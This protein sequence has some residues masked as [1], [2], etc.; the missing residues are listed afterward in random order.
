MAQA[1][2]SDVHSKPLERDDEKLRLF[3]TSW[4]GRWSL[5]FANLCWF[6]DMQMPK[7]TT[8]LPSCG[9]LG[10]RLQDEYIARMLGDLGIPISAD[11]NIFQLHFTD[12]IKYTGRLRGPQWRLVNR[13]EQ[14]PGTSCKERDDPGFS[15]GCEAEG[16]TR[17]ATKTQQQNVRKNLCLIPH[18]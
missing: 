11:D 5:A 9:T 2:D 10:E 4:E 17:T 12:L 7:P 8:H 1:I 16:V 15:R 14:R 18:P 3:F 13:I 6:R